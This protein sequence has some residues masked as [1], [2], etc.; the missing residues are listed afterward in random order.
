MFASA[1]VLWEWRGGKRIITVMSDE[2]QSLI[3]QYCLGYHMNIKL[4]HRIN[5][6][7][8]SASFKDD[9]QKMFLKGPCLSDLST[10]AYLLP[11]R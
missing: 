8:F 9:R 6:S 11:D 4:G 5:Y 1:F 7:F 10:L 2:V 3:I